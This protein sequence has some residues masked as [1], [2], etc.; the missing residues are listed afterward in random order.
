M[1]KLLGYMVVM[2][3]IF[4]MEACA[5]SNGEQQADIEVAEA[6]DPADEKLPFEIKDNVIFNENVPVVVDF[7]ATWCG[8]CKQ[9][10]PTFH[11]VAEKFSGAACFVSIDVDQYPEL[12]KSYDVKA[13]PSTVFISPGGGVLGMENGVLSQ[14]QLEMYVNQLVDTASGEDMEV[15]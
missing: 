8:P 11:A 2:L 12:A 14:E 6:F 3:A 4:G 7:F 1:K 10:A 9:Y 15:L 5:K 13:V